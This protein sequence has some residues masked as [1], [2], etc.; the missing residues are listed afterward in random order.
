MALE[1]VGF[2]MVQGPMEN[3]AE[4]GKSVLHGK[5]NGKLEQDLGGGQAIKFG[6]HGDEAVKGD[7]KV[8]ADANVPKDAVEE[9]PEAKQIH[10]FYFVRCRPYEDPNIKAKIDQLDKEVSKQNQARFQVT[11]AL[12]AKRSERAE[13]ISQIKSL[14]G[15][16]RQF[17]SI[18]DEKRKEIEPLQQA[19]GKLR[20]GGQGGLC[21]SEEELNNAI[22]SLQYRIQHE[23]I[24]LSEEKQILREIKQLEGTRGQVIVN[25]AERAKLQESL[26]QK[27]TIQDQVKLIGGDLSGVKKE[28][29]AVMSKIQQIDKALKKINEDIESLQVELDDITEKREKAYE[30]IQQLRKQRDDGNLYFYQSRQLLN[31]AKELAAKKDINA[32]E[33]FAH[34]E[35]E[36]FMSLWNGDKTFRKDYEKRILTSLDMRQM[37]RDGRIRNP[38]EK[39]LV[40]VP[41]PAETAVVSKTIPKQPKEEPKPTPKEILPTQVVQKESKNKGKDSKSKPDNKDL[42]EADEYDFENPH[43]EIPVKKPEIDAKQLKEIKRQEEIAKAKLALER[44]KKLADKA[45]AKAALRAEKEAEKKLKDREKKAKKKGLGNAT[46]P[47]AEEPEDAVVEA[48]EQEKVDEIVEAVAPVKEKVRK[49][50]VIRSRSRA[51]GPEKIQKAI[52][53]RKKSNNYWVWVAAAALLVLILLVLG[54]T[55][56]F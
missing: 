33:A 44:K 9:W 47:G 8:V 49:E 11:E 19:L 56:L 31:K 6:S 41:K 54:Y 10:Y 18:V 20:N 12:R 46:V 34:S 45:A 3:S 38:D 36:K 37:S 15:D 39:P 2:E 1:V 16:N 50:S 25:A 22:Y 23:S 24:P 14:R 52:L 48:T 26:G 40:E 53:K 30:S 13:L 7:A 35:V 32:L 29:Q 43:K 5:D 17:R 27:D 4:G 55:Y 28:K 21:S 51:S 42:A